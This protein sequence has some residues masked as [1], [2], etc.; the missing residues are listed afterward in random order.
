MIHY[1]RGDFFKE[2]SERNWARNREK[3]RTNVTHIQIWRIRV[4]FWNHGFGHLEP[5]IWSIWLPAHIVSHCWLNIST[6]LTKTSGA[7][8]CWISSKS[9]PY[10]RKKWRKTNR[11]VVSHQ[12][13]MIQKNCSFI[14]RPKK[15]VVEK[16]IR[17]CLCQEL[18]DFRRFFF[19]FGFE[20]GI[21][22]R[23][24][25]PPCHVFPAGSKAPNKA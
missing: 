23:G 5:R 17:P 4:P 14:F 15:Y 20:M 12:E 25:T 6:F 16:P 13:K 8:C 2:N 9:I 3:K 1:I 24:P 21:P 10:P 19:L 11:P 22:R 7:M 18:S